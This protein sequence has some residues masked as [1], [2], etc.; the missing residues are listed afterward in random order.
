MSADRSEDNSSNS[1][2][3]SGSSPTSQ[4]NSEHTSPEHKTLS[5]TDL[6]ASAEDD[7]QLSIALE[8]DNSTMSISAGETNSKTVADSAIVLQESDSNHGS[9]EAFSTSNGGDS[10]V[11]NDSGVNNNGNNLNGNLSYN[12]IVENGASNTTQN[13]VAETHQHNRVEKT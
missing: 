9:S 11:A 13:G 5:A 10:H 2:P 7:L 12:A 1:S 4:P 3:V 6:S 8:G